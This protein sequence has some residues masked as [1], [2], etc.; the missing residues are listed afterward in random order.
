VIVVFD[1]GVLVSALHFGGTPLAALHAASIH[2]SIALCTEI[3][4]E[5]QKA[6]T[7]KLKW[8]E[9]EANRVL[10]ALIRDARLVHISGVLSGACRDPKD[11]IILECA[12]VAE[13]DFIVSGDNDLLVLEQYAGIRIVTPRAFL[14]AVG[15]A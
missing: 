3:E 13:A 2:S 9:T 5:V 12:V 15:T 7:G 8:P 4:E 11:H 14:S 6:L 1:S 10:Q